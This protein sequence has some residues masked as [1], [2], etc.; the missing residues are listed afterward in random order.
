MRGTSSFQWN[1]GERPALRRFRVEATAAAMNQG[2]R[3]TGIAG[4][5]VGRGAGVAVSYSLS[6][7]AD[8]EV[9]ILGSN[10]KAIRKLLSRS[11]RAAGMNQTVWDQKNDAGVAMPAGAYVVEIRAQSADGQQSVRA[12]QPILVVR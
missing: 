4:R 2:L 9:R 8:V 5:S 12:A 3:I 11:S 6:S 1:T 10:G 7:S